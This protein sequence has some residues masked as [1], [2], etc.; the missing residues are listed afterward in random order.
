MGTSAAERD[1]NE[2]LKFVETGGAISTRT[3]N[4]EKNEARAIDTTDGTVIYCGLAK[5]ES[6]TSSAVWQIKRTTITG[7]V[8]QIEWADSNLNYDNVFDNRASLTYG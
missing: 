1:D 6:L 3:K 4:S 7:S 2:G 5:V 8:I